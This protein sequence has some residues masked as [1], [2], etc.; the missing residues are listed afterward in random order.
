M[1]SRPPFSKAMGTCSLGQACPALRQLTLDRGWTEDL[2][3][4]SGCS[5]DANAVTVSPGARHHPP[6][7]SA[8]HP[9]LSFCLSPPRQYFKKQQRLI[10]ERTVWKY[11]VQLCSAVEHMHSRRVMHRGACAPPSRPLGTSPGQSDPFVWP[12]QAGVVVWSAL[13][14]VRALGDTAPTHPLPCVLSLPAEGGLSQ[15]PGSHMG[16]RE[17]GP[18]SAHHRQPPGPARGRHGAG[19]SKDGWRGRLARGKGNEMPTKDCFQKLTSS[20]VVRKAPSGCQEGCWVLS[21][22]PLHR[23]LHSVV[24]PA[25]TSAL[26]ARHSPSHLSVSPRTACPVPETVLGTTGR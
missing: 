13:S 6:R 9:S 22:G 19:R 16:P 4:R 14:R 25:P 24:P 15:K 1:Q 12:R 10:P 18:R 5:R 11:F 3:G 26:R 17:Q 7:L 20:R 21:H 23:F 8:P 2:G